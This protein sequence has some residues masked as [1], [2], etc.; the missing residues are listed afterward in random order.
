MNETNHHAAGVAA[1]LDRCRDL[2]ITRWR[3][4]V[5]RDPA[6]PWARSLPVPILDNHFPD[7]IRQISLCLT[8]DRHDTGTEAGRVIGTSQIARHHA[9]NR[10]QHGYSL[11]AALTELAHAREVLIEACSRERIE[12]S[13]ETALLLHR[14]IDEAM[15]TAASEMAVR[16][17]AE[18]RQTAEFRERFIGILGHDLRTPLTAIKA[19]ADLALR[20]GD[21]AEPVYRATTQR[22]LQRIARGADRMN[23]MITDVL[24]LTMSRQGGGIPLQ[25]KSTDLAEVCQNIVDE[26]A[27]T[28]PD[29][30]IRL[31]A[32]GAM[33]GDWDPDRVQQVV[34]NLIANALA[35]SP[36]STPV[37]VTLTDTG[38]TVQLSVANQGPPISPQ[39][40][41]TMF[42]P[43]KRGKQALEGERRPGLGLGLFI[44][45]AIVKAHGGRITVESTAKHGTT[46]TV[47]WPRTATGIVPAAA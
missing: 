32:H 38:P 7:M 16:A 6:I 45:D 26:L 19:S 30:S 28:H 34:A 15:I 33:R 42:D 17:A 13:G 12:L 46:F 14:A 39:D 35:Y 27:V 36:T 20:M 31:I 1:M 8:S 47:D 23:R 25:P 44:V 22:S 40:R 18:L 2:L 24:D 3:E 41:A 5:L 9:E 43:F 4:L 11:E 10:F 37:V 21:E 29:R